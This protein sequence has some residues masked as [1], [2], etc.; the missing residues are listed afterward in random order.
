MWKE[1]YSLGLRNVTNISVEG[2]TRLCKNCPTIEQ[3]DLNGCTG[4]NDECVEVIT[5]GLSNL[6]EIDLS[7]TSITEK[8]LD[9]ISNNC[10]K[11]K[12]SIELKNLYVYK[13]YSIIGT[14]TSIYF[15]IECQHFI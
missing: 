11:I 5:K 2:F 10:F 12:V 7:G 15:L 4:I 13:G 14:K 1:L 3:L 8:A 6:K 9:H